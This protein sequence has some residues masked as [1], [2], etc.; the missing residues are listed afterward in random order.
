MIIRKACG[1]PAIRNGSADSPAESGIWLVAFAWAAHRNGTHRRPRPS[2][3]S[4][5]VSPTNGANQA[6]NKTKAS[7]ISLLCFTMIIG[8]ALLSRLSKASA[9]GGLTA[10]RCR[11]LPLGHE[12]IQPENLIVHDDAAQQIQQTGPPLQPGRA[13]ATCKPQ[14]RRSPFVRLKPQLDLQPAPGV[15]SSS[16][17]T[18]LL[19]S[20][21]I[22]PR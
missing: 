19:V 11:A 14:A 6:K 12:A 16:R 10:S 17:P 4:A 2:L 22:Q 1:P 20:S 8:G 21:S 5:H 7:H 13:A 15:R 9:V 3:D 18:V